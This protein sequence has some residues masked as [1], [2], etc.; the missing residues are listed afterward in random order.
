MMPHFVVLI[1]G[2]LMLAFG[3]LVPSG[4]AAYEGDQPAQVFS[5]GSP[6]V[7]GA[8]GVGKT[9]TSFQVPPGK[10]IVNGVGVFS[11]GT[12]LTLGLITM[13]ISSVDN[14]QPTAASA[15]L[16]VAGIAT[17]TNSYMTPINVKVNNA[18]DNAVM[19]YLVGSASYVTLGT[20]TWTIE[21]LVTLQKD[22]L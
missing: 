15:R 19:Y 5:P 9:I 6:V 21:S 3:A 16:A 18:T 12:V 4:Q 20:A 7:P 13:G 8:S 17:V 2:F 1:V 11:P 22:K 10:W 14:T